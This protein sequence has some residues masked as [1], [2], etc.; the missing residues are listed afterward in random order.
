MADNGNVIFRQQLLSVDENLGKEDVED[1][2]FLCSDFI[3]LKKLETV[4]SAQDIFQLLINKDLVNRD[5]TFLIAELLYMIKCNFLLQ[6]LGYT[7]EIVQEHQPKRGK[8]SGY[9]QMLYEIAEELTKDQVKSAA[10]LLKDHLPKKQSTMSALELLTSLEKKS[11][12]KESDLSILEEI[13]QRIAPHLLKKVVT[14]RQTKGIKEIVPSSVRGFNKPTFG[15]TL[16]QDP[17]Q[18]KNHEFGSLEEHV[19]S[20]HSLAVN[21][22]VKAEPVSDPSGR[23]LQQTVGNDESNAATERSSQYKMDG[24]CK[25]YCLIINNVNFEGGLRRRSGSE[26][27]ASKWLKAMLILG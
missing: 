23:S 20:F 18:P 15:I 7:K 1:L 21:Q 24:R 3:P 2:K 27:D 25:G 14:Y 10:F 12:L 5:D 8:V 11:L 16:L 9:R 6:K 4:T 19:G 17:V 22:A 26:K 13:C